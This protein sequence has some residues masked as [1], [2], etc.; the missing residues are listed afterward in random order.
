MSDKEREGTILAA[1]LREHVEVLANAGMN[2]SLTHWGLIS[3]TMLRAANL[4][5]LI[6]RQI[7]PAVQIAPFAYFQWNSA[8]GA[9]EHVMNRAAGQDGVIAA[10]RAPPTASIPSARAI[11]K[12]I[13]PKA[14]DPPYDEFDDVHDA[15]DGAR[16][17]ALA[18]AEE[19]AAMLSGVT[20]DDHGRSQTEIAQLRKALESANEA[21][22]M[23]TLTYAAD[24]CNKA[25]VS[26]AW[27]RI[28]ASGGTLAFI[29]DIQDE[30]RCALKP[31][32]ASN[33][34]P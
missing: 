8:W 33:D 17:E 7:P 31:Q 21:I 15:I 29:G 16:R 5:A 1:R 26:R 12:I 11:A 24:M 22:N 13:N 10:C 4:L 30:I 3:H 25:D 9:W 34:A 14:F 6:D 2:L 32:G 18:K 20:P 23:W 19:I 28:G 27:D